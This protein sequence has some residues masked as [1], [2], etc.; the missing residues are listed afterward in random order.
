MSAVNC[1]AP[2]NSRTTKPTSYTFSYTNY[3]PMYTNIVYIYTHVY[4]FMYPKR[5]VL[6][7][8]NHTIVYTL[9]MYFAG[10]MVIF[11]GEKI[12]WPIY[13]TANPSLC[14]KKQKNV[15]ISM[16]GGNGQQKKSMELKEQNTLIKR[17]K[18]HDL[19]WFFKIKQVLPR[20]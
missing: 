12:V 2:F 1:S 3:I 8:L 15:V 10:A 14:P 5:K 18:T 9:C 13:F 17:Q 16:I 19:T 4:S 7:F 6:D 11:G 20:S